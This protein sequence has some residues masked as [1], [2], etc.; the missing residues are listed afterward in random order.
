MNPYEAKNVPRLTIEKIS[1]SNPLSNLVVKAKDLISR[2]GV[3][4]EKE[5]KSVLPK[6][7]KIVITFY[8]NFLN[9]YQQMN[10]PFTIEFDESQFS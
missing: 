5:F 1:E 3:Q 2:M 10:Q 8:V 7:F 9:I 4:D 6:M